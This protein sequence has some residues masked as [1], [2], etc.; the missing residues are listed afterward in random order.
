MFAFLNY[1]TIERWD[2]R[3]RHGFNGMCHVITCVYF[4]LE[5]HWMMG[6]AMFF[7]ARISFDTALNLMRG[8]KI[9]YVS[10]NPKSIIDK[11]EKWVFGYNGVLP[12]VLY[13]I[14]AIVLNYFLLR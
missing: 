1:L 4:G 7:T 10:V 11:L 3:V 6:T 13:L 8:K 5:V 12:K 9:G 2:E 14:I